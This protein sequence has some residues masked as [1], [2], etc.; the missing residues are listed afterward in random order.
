MFCSKC[1]HQL[2][3]GTKIC[4]NCN[5][6]VNEGAQSEKPSTNNR[7]NALQTHTVP[8][9]TR[10]GH[11]GAMK[12]GPLF[13]KNDIIWMLLLFI[14]AF[15]GFVYLAYILITRGNPKRR[16]KICPHCGAK[17]MY[18]YLY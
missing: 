16:E 18:T 3:E 6:E 9:C 15:G 1:G 10:C 17:N 8:K 5:H 12:P 4:P 7:S 13:R 14:T 11:V 2:T